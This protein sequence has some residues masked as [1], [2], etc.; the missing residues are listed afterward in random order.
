MFLF[1]VLSALAFAVWVVFFTLCVLVSV[2]GLVEVGMML[3]RDAHSRLLG[4]GLLCDRDVSR[5][6]PHVGAALGSAIV[7]HRTN[8]EDSV[9]SAPCTPSSDDAR[10]V[11]VF[12]DTMHMPGDWPVS[13]CFS[14]AWAAHEVPLRYPIT[15]IAVCMCAPL[16]AWGGE[17]GVF[18]T[19]Q[20]ALGLLLYAVN[21]LAANQLA[22]GAVFNELPLETAQRAVD[23][24]FLGLMFS[25]SALA[26]PISRVSLYI[27][28]ASASEIIRER[29][30][31]S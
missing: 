7:V 24:D 2:K 4:G 30:Q 1:S 25:A 31:R 15:G 9:V 13:V 6:V 19:L 17:V 5:T 16:V 21:I 14:V 23:G 11:V 29:R 10:E 20:A 8:S 12:V 28:R 26:D 22:L 18:F 27:M 3:Q